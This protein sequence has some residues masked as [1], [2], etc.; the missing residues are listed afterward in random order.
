MKISRTGLLIHGF[1]L[2]HFITVLICRA[3]GVGDT[4]ILTFLTILLSVLICLKHALTVEFT[5]IILIVANIAGFALGIWIAKGAGL[6]IPGDLWQH[7]VST[8]LTTEILGWGA[9]WFIQKFDSGEKMSERAGRSKELFS[10]IVA[11]AIIFA[12]RV[13]IDLMA[14]SGQGDINRAF[15][16]FLGNTGMMLLM[17]AACIIFLQYYKKNRKELNSYGKV[18]LLVQLLI[19][20]ALS[21]ALFVW[22]GLPMNFRLDQDSGYFM[23]LL[24]V[25]FICTATI[26]STVYLT[27]YAL[28]ARR[29]IEAERDEANRA[30]F[31]YMSLKQQVNPHFLF[32]SLN[33]LDALV[34]EGRNKDAGTYIHKLA[35]IYRYM[36]H[37]ER[38][39]V[40][41]LS[42]E[43][44]FTQMYIDLL[45]LRFPEGLKVGIS[46]PEG[47]KDRYVVPCSVQL[48]VENATKHNAISASNPLMVD[49]SSDGEMLCVSNNRIPKV[50]PVQ[51]TGLGLNYIRQQYLDISGK[52]A[53]VLDAPA[54]FTVKLPLL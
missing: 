39:S 30:R 21:S 52:R 4:L 9:E 44:T 22:L 15:T 20:V 2:L 37:N 42:D 38:E 28:D 48:L 19:I 10:L 45:T 6:L 25:A 3:T 23:N 12:V 31:Q 34:A 33:V 41:P 50:S 47:D 29:R 11:V 17:V 24:L 53:E 14:S 35:G 13:V 8:L 49:I 43:L 46:V 7:A 1:A 32:N 18:M 36:L 51:S 27:D 40:V 16:E 5:A 26:F 54:A